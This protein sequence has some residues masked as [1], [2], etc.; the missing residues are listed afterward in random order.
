MSKVAS[1]FK[2]TQME[3][4][5]HTEAR[6]SGPHKQYKESVSL[7]HPV[8]QLNQSFPLWMTSGFHFFYHSSS[9]SIYFRVL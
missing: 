5:E 6:F 1:F 7:K 8:D 4:K 3:E 9:N 2:L